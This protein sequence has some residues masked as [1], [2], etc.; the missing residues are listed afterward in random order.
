MKR[1][2]VLALATNANPVINATSNKIEFVDG[3]TYARES[4]GFWRRVKS[5]VL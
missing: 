3:T 1:E 5:S 4:F 2:E